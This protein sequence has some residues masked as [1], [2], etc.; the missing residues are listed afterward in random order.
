MKVAMVGLDGVGTELL[1]DAIKEFGLINLKKFA[2]SIL[3]LR[4]YPPY[5]PIAWTS[6]L[7]G[8]DPNK[9]GIYG[10]IKIIRHKNMFNLKLNSSKDVLFPRIFEILATKKRGIILNVPFIYPFKYVYGYRNCIMLSDYFSP[11]I[12]LW[13]ENLHAKYKY[14]LEDSVPPDF[15][16]ENFSEAFI[17]FVSELIAGRTKLYL[18]LIETIDWDFFICIFSVIDW[19]E[20]SIG[21]Y[22]L[23][24][25]KENGREFYDYL[26]EIFRLIDYIVG[27]I[28]SET[29]FIVLTSDHGFSL[30]RIRVNIYNLLEHLKLMKIDIITKFRLAINYIA[31]CTRNPYVGALF[32][33]IRNFVNRHFFKI[34]ELR[35]PVIY[36]EI[37]SFFLYTRKKAIRE[38]LDQRALVFGHKILM[39][40]K[41]Y[42][43]F[44][45]YVNKF[46]PDILMIALDDV[47]VAPW[48]R[49]I[50]E[51]MSG[52]DHSLYNFVGFYFKRSVSMLEHIS[53]IKNLRLNNNESMPLLNLSIYDIAPLMLS[54]VGMLYPRFYNISPS[55]KSLLIRLYN[56][57]AQK[58]IR[59]LYRR[60]LI[61]HKVRALCY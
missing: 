9:H 19:L 42:S 53:L 44:S 39:K 60:L 43:T 49:E 11:K 52:I 48:G 15:I 7:T 4:S 27:K 37:L 17:K 47:Y 18:N 14:F 61:R 36:P 13:P 5:T 55:L 28:L 51:S 34:N 40:F 2:K 38:Y 29:D 1:L 57:S 59:N 3:T 50:I 24:S 8:V 22:N 10:F 58:N 6:I 16:E 21:F 23:Q 30:K 12:K 20:H 45:S 46:S 25:L 54:A 32:S 56:D 35:L 31:Q 26:K 41:R 33:I